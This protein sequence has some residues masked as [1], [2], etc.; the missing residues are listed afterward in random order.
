MHEVHVAVGEEPWREESSLSDEAS[1]SGRSGINGEHLTAAVISVDVGVKAL[2]DERGALR[3]ELADLK[4]RHRRELERVA[5]AVADAVDEVW[6]QHLR[7]SEVSTPKT[8]IDLA[9]IIAGVKL[10]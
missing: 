2:L 7:D 10:G 8:E 5:A 4:E 9:A 6:N 1:D 3:R